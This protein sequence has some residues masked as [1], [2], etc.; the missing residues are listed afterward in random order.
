[1]MV[2]ELSSYYILICVFCVFTSLWIWICCTLFG[3]RRRKIIPKF[4]NFVQDCGKQRRQALKYWKI[5]PKFSNFVQAWTKIARTLQ[6]SYFMIQYYHPPNFQISSNLLGCRASKLERRMLFYPWVFRKIKGFLFP[7]LAPEGI[8]FLRK[9][10][11]K[12]RGDILRVIRRDFA[13]FFK[14][15]TIVLIITGKLAR[16]ELSIF[17]ELF[18][19]RHSFTE[20][21]KNSDSA[22]I[23]LSNFG[24]S[25]RNTTLH[26]TLYKLND[27][28]NYTDLN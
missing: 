28:L 16:S 24:F 23:I 4:S 27:K 7:G 12:L 20:G 8:I 19:F 2:N 15:C 13:V 5:I 17:S 18:W 10:F 3:G 25:A 11:T 22:G 26:S 1:M 14:T 9:K 6:Y 21:K